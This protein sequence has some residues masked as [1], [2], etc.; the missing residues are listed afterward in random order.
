MKKIRK[1]SAHSIPE[2]FKMVRDEMGDDALILGT[3]RVSQHGDKSKRVEVVAATESGR[4]KQAVGSGVAR[5]PQLDT[6]DP[7][8]QRLRKTDKTLA[9]ELRQIESRLRELLDKI[10]VPAERITEAPAEA[11]GM[12]LREAGFDPAIIR[13]RSL[14]NNSNGG[15]SVET[16]IEDLI[17]RIRV[18]PSME[19]ISVFLGSSGSGKTTT[20][21]KIT[22][23]VLLPMGLKPHVVYFGADDGRSSAWLSSQCRKLRVRFR[24][25]SSV[26]KLDKILRKAGKHPVLIDTPGISDL[27]DQELSFLA[28]A[29]KTYEGMRIRL[30]VD[31][32]MD[33]RNICAIASCVPED[34]PVSLVLTKLD[35]VTSIGGAVSMAI[36][37]RTPLAYLTGGKD[38]H[39]GI[40]AADA[41]LVSDKVL[42]GLKSIRE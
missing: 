5:R 19:R 34:S 33:P 6:T 37:T 41:S 14:S 26:A 8:I 36:D 35:E 7:D 30:V 23:G 22:A 27:S 31:S 40:Y 21:L 25:V 15:C 13:N 16:L 18:E 12:A 24:K 20:I 17:D 9:A 28:A 38:L 29:S 10:I 1:F 42:E 32:G 4:R 3:T 2:A 39:S 11:A